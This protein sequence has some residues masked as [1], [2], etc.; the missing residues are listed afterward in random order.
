MIP[1]CDATMPLPNLL[2]HKIWLG[3]KT[4]QSINYQIDS[5]YFFS[6]QKIQFC[7]FH[8]HLEQKKFLRFVESPSLILGPGFEFHL[9][10]CKFLHQEKGH[11]TATD[12]EN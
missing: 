11:D 12:L 7:L 6:V 10:K 4:L 3:K 8:P 2:R 1:F 5:I 9:F